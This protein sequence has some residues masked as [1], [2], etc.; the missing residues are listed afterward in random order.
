[1]L[2]KTMRQNFKVVVIAKNLVRRIRKF[3]NYSVF[4]KFEISLTAD[5][6]KVTKMFNNTVISGK[7]VDTQ[8]KLV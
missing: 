3:F 5:L 8:R 4:E 2:G 7:K 1:M 6:C